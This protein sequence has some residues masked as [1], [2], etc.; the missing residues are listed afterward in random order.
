VDSG[1]SGGSIEITN[2][3]RRTRPLACDA[4]GFIFSFYKLIPVLTA[5][6]NVETPL[7]LDADHSKENATCENG[8]SSGQ[9]G[10]R[11]TIIRQ[12]SARAAGGIAR[13]MLRPAICADEPT[14]IW[15]AFLPKNSGVDGRLNGI[16]NDNHHGDS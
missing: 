16:P 15:T 4:L 5:F 10:H 11:M 12:L 3:P 6:E 7:H 9:S 8:P 14:V 13:A 2:F 1:S